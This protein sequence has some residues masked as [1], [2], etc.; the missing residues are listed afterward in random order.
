MRKRRPLPRPEPPP[1]GFVLRRGKSGTL[2]EFPITMIEQM[3]DWLVKNNSDP[4]WR[5]D[6]TYNLRRKK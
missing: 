3:S 1:E 2:E 4:S 6:P 5:N